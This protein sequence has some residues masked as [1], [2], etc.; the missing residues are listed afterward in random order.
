MDLVE[1]ETRPEGF[2]ALRTIAMPAD[3][4]PAGQIFGGWLMSQMDL[5]GAIHAALRAKGKVAT[6]AVDGMKF[7]APVYVG[8]EV[9]CYTKLD[10]VGTTSLSIR[11]EVWVRRA[12]RTAH[13]KVTSALFHFVAVG[14]DYRPR[15][16]PPE[17]ARMEA[18]FDPC[19]DL[20]G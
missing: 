13:T 17:E 5:A 4:N 1:S 18:E 20:R 3:T 14:E 19:K 12:G 7:H 15:P 9:S 8:D 16:V 11:I 6:V 10:R 2:L